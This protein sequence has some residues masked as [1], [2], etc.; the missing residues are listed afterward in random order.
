M[1]K[2]KKKYFIIGGL[3]LLLALL[4]FGILYY[5]NN[6][7][8]SYSFSEKSWIN[9]NNNIAIDVSIESGLPLF[10]SNGEGVFYDYINMMERDTGLTFNVKIG[11]E[12]DYVFVNKNKITANDLNFYTD[13]YVLISTN[14]NTIHDLNEII[15][16]PI[17]IMTYDKEY[18]SNYLNNYKFNYKDYNNI[19]TLKNDMNTTIIYA[20]VPMYKYMNEI[21]Y[22]KYNIVYHIE[23]LHSHYVLSMKES[24]D[25]S[26]LSSVFTKFFNK[27]EDDVT[28][29]INRHYL[30]L[31]YNA[32]SLSDLDKESIIGDDLIVGYIENMPYEGKINKSFSGITDEYLSMFAEMTGATYKYIKYDNVDRLV[33]ALNNNKVDLVFNNYNITNENYI[34]SVN[35]GNISYAI[36]TSQDNIIAIDSLE[37]V[38]DDRVKMVNNTMLHSYIKGKNID[39]V[40]YDN[41]KELFKNV[42]NSDILIVEKSAYDFYKNSSLKDYVIRFIETTDNGNTFLLNKSNTVLNNMFNFYLS[43][44]GNKRVFQASVSHSLEDSSTN[45]LI[46]FIFKNITYILA[47]IFATS[48]LLFKF[49]RKVKVTKKIKKEDKMLYLD[50][51]TNLKNR[52]YLNDNL[53]YWESNKIYPQAVVV[54]DLN[55][56]A[57]IN[58]T[59]GHEEGDLQIKSAASILIKTQRENTEI[60]RSDGNEFLIYMVGYDE[61]Q[62]VTY[63]NKL[64]KEF[65]TLP[66]EYGASVG[67]HLIKTDSTTIDDAINEALI[68]MRENKGK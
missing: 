53:P 41:Y 4:V 37:S 61:K 42:K 15:N 36:V 29:S 27:R 16:Q 66:Y 46:N 30:N 50:V 18:V 47:L 22:N 60:I 8:D 21:V 9:S 5:V 63:V 52:N 48:F 14:K 34:S 39:V 51:M 7:K 67:Y 33:D 1:R 12:G 65:K 35:L 31:Y 62:V 19:E 11:N 45:I 58:D 57:V 26:E 49:N 25:S 38:R 43:T 2:N 10:S 56:I 68:M 44:L 55:D 3:I 23:G 20:I 54:V 17:G 13:H 28:K 59:K 24:S 32:S 6:S 40:T 64:I